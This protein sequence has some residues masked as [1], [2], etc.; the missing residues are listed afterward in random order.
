VVTLEIGWGEMEVAGKWPGVGPVAF[1]FDMFWIF[2]VRE[3][4][5]EVIVLD[6]AM[7]VPWAEKVEI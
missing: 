1:A 6:A 3:F 7:A 4:N 5:A 2:V